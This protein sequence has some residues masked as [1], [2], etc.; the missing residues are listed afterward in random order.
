MRLIYKVLLLFGV[1]FG[2]TTA[3]SADKIKISNVL[4]LEVKG[5]IGPAT[6]DYIKQGI[7]EAGKK[8]D[9]VVIKLDTPGGLSTSMRGIIQAILASPVPVITYVSPSGARAASAGTYILYASHIAAMAPGTN[10]GAATPVQMG[11]GMTPGQAEPSAGKED[12]KSG[13]STESAVAKSSMEKKAI[14]DASAYIRSLAEL[15]GRNVEWA[16][17]AVNSADS[18]S[19]EQALKLGVIDVIANNVN[20]L[21]LSINGKSVV[22][23]GKTLV[24]DSTKFSLHYYQPNWRNR[25]LAVITNP[26]IAYILLMIGLYGLIF[27]FMN[28]GA[29]VPGVIGAICLIFAGYA[30]Q[31]LPINYAGLL[32]IF[33]GVA[34]L[35]AEAFVSSFGILGIGGIVALVIGS[36]LLFDM[37]MGMPQLAWEIIAVFSGVSILFFVGIIGMVFRSRARNIVSGSEGLIGLEA[38][39]RESQG[40]KCRVLVQGELWNAQAGTPVKVG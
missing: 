5:A 9:M 12:E 32:L 6:Q 13:Q 21:M 19:A 11:G 25:L 40:D 2:L 39:V 30:L 38:T 26:N 3:I 27:E 35:V 16:Q 18:I 10:V 15:R 14:A 29:I 33:L 20:D 36:V 28:P 1:C 37:P 31:M 17:R 24:I 4:V 8:S 34:F 23:G 7:R 22:L